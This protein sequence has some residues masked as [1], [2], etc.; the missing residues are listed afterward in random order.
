MEGLGLLD[1]R[2]AADDVEKDA[3]HEGLVVDFGVGLDIVL[4]VALLDQLVD[5]RTRLAQVG[6]FRIGLVG[7]GGGMRSSDREGDQQEDGG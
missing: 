2:D 1:R 7:S 6:A 5:F 4:G 3:P